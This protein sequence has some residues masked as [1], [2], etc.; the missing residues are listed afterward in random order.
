MARSEKEAKP[1]KT[2][3]GRALAK[4]QP[5]PR[6]SPEEAK[7][8]ILEAARQLLAERG[9]DAVGLKDVARAAGVSHALVSHYFGTYGELV[10][11]VMEA[12]VLSYR[13]ELLSEI[14]RSPDASPAAW[15]DRL[16]EQIAD[17]LHARLSMWAVLSGRLERDDFF[18]RRQQGLRLVADAIE[19]RIGELLPG[20]TPP[21]REDLERLLALVIVSATGYSAMRSLLWPMFGRAATPERDRNFRELLLRVVLREA[22][23]A[24]RKM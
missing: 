10:E 18:S 24:P 19:A 7:R 4:P 13:A 14:T 21:A 3:R 8:T 1:K 20:V 6:R 9:P 11:A 12:H 15:L 16:F 23:D 5:R 22:Q 2:A 17:P